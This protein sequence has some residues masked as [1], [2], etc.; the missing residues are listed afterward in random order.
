MRIPLTILLLSL[1]LYLQAQSS[2]K[3]NEVC[4]RNTNIICDD[5]L[6][7]ED[8]IEIYNDD[9]ISLDLSQYYLTDDKNEIFK[10]QFPKILLHPKK[11]L[12]VFASGKDRK[13][14]INHWETAVFGDS[15]WKYKNPTDENTTEYD[16]SH[17]SDYDYED[18]DW[19]SGYGAF[20]DSISGYEQVQTYTTDSIPSIFLRKE[21]F[22]SDTSKILSVILH[23]YYDDGFTTYINGYEVLRRNMVHDGIRPHYNKT[24][25]SA[26][27]S[28][29]DTEEPPEEFIIE[30]RFFKNLLKNGKNV[31]AIQTHNFWK[32]YPKVIKAWLSV[33]ISDSIYQFDTIPKFLSTHELPL[34]SNFKINGDGEKIYIYDSLGQQVYKFSTPPLSTNISAG[35][36]P[37][38]PDSIVLY[39]LPSPG[40]ENSLNAHAGSITDSVLLLIPSGYYTDSVNIGVLNTSNFIIKYTTDGSLPRDTSSIYDSSFYVKSNTVLRFRYFS[41]SL[42]P[43]PVSNYSYFIN[44]SCS[45]DFFSIITDPHNL[46]DDADGIYAYGTHFVHSP[47]YFEAN[48]W[49]N[50][51]RPAHIQHFLASGEQSWQQDAGIK[52]HGNYTRMIPQKSFGFYAKSDYSVSRFKHTLFTSKPSIKSYKRF[53]LKNAGNDFYYTHLR[54]LLIHLR[55]RNESIDVQSGQP[56]TIYLNGE[57]WGIYHLREKIDRYYIEDNWGVKP[58]SVNLLEQNGLIISGERNNFENLMVFIKNNDLSIPYNY[59]HVKDEIDVES[60]TNCLISNLYH[61]NTDWPHHNTKFWNAPG[62]K[63]RQI[64]VDQDVTMA[65]SIDNSADKNSL[66]RIHEDSTSYLAIFY[67]EL[68][69]SKEFK[70]QYINRFADLMNTIFLTDNY[71]SLLDS[72]SAVLNPEMQRHAARWDKNYD[73]W[74]NLY[75]PKISTFI[76][77]RSAYMR[78]DLREFYD[79]GL[80]DTITIN[81]Q[82]NGRIKL[83]SLYING[84]NWTGLYFDSIP[85]YLEAI[86][87]PGYEFVGWESPTS[88]ELADSS[89]IIKKWFLK[90]HDTIRAHYFSPSGGPDTLQI[91]FTE[92]NY[93]SFKNA[94]AGDWIEIFNKE[95][96]TINLSNWTVKGLKPYKKWMIPNGVKIA[97]Q[98]RMVLV[99]DTSLFRKEHP[100]VSSY[101]GPFRY[102]LN[103]QT[104]TISLWDDLDRRVSIITFTSKNP[105]PDNENTAKTIELVDT[106]HNYQNASNWVLGCPGGSPSLAPHDCSKNIELLFTEINYKST[107][108]YNSGDWVEILNN[109]D[110]TINLSHWIFKDSNPKHNFVFSKETELAAHQKII[111]VQ[112]TGLYFSVQARDNRIYGP[113]RFGLS[114]SGENISLSNQFDQEIISLSYSN[115]NPWPDDAS[116]SGYTIEL[117]NEDLP[118]EDGDNWQANCFLGTPLQAPGWCIQPESII[119]SEVKYQSDSINETGDWIELFNTNNRS[120][121]LLNWKLIHQGDTLLIDTNYLLESQSYITLTANSSLFYQLHDTITPTIS[122]DSFNLKKEEDIIFILNPYQ[123]AGNILSYHYLLNWPVFQTDTNNRTLELINYQNS[124]DPDNWRAGCDFGTPSKAPSFCNTEGIDYRP[125]TNYQILVHPNP[126]TGQTNIEISLT[127]SEAIEIRAIDTQSNIVYFKDLGI[128]TAGMHIIK[129]NLHRL[130][131]GIYLIEVRGEQNVDKQKVIKIK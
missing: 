92:I 67:Q 54:D 84:D 73:T 99:Q 89:R 130:Q 78:D 68:M 123:Q 74:L 4:S 38:F 121:S 5:D 52:I 13:K 94:E 70:I 120:V 105:W 122:I 32:Q 69:K 44:D 9:S 83:N 63:W 56:S 36:H 127:K 96:D 55:M 26:H 61:F 18:G 75:L 90:S 12:L 106:D 124:L 111:L 45:L 113:T 21:F 28:K 112:D 40:L 49:Q 76:S 88:P 60:W 57:Y 85:V 86:P 110:S 103:S 10:W 14:I 100:D 108:K 50:W 11:Y 53:L 7:F 129:L 98:Q 42:L 59:Q 82:A 34:H 93:R 1:G 8:W 79:L 29:I 58:D 64:L 125:P 117:T 72:L 116:G 19:L 77:E 71:Q 66:V 126:F 43:G 15:L 35:L 3:I 39:E 51:E 107:E 16:Y 31:L 62:Y 6:D 25:F 65:Y 30:P 81:N 27:P 115:S 2:L 37:Q 114:A 24:A 80:N 87:N 118:M 95:D 33:A 109:S 131:S 48:F 128:L 101:I 23:A 102:G 119:I 47:P 97:P 46:W 17:W 91:L 41:D 22:I 104:E 20:G